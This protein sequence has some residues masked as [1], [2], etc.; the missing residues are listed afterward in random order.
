MTSV[1]II[2]NNNFIS[3]IEIKGHALSAQYGSDTVCA[4]ISTVV[5]GFCNALAEL[6]SYNEDQINF[7]EELIVIPNISNYKEIQ[8]ICEVLIVQLKTIEQSY[9]KYIEISFQ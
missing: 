6:T 9:P 4:G 1:I 5:F 7:K 3:N 8:L 2:R